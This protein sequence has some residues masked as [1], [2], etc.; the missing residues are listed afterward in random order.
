MAL[1]S[2]LLAAPSKMRRFAAKDARCLVASAIEASCPLPRFK[3][4]RI[5]RQHPSRLFHASA[6]V[7]VVKPYL[8][9]DIGEGMPGR[10]PVLVVASKQKLTGSRRYHRVS[11]HPMV[12]PA[13]RACRAVRQDMRG[14][15]GQG[16]RRSNEAT[17]RTK[18]AF[19]NHIRRSHRA[20]MA[21]SKSYTMRQTRW[22]RLERSA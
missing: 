12:R 2:H 15:V 13:G 10:F 4:V 1:S 20:S 8:L 21:L 7:Q 9:A 6:A 11:G 19:A 14:A 5:P 18:L 22:P 16:H 3:N 17:P